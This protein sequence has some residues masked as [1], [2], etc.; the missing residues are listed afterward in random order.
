MLP[1]RDA[2]KSCRSTQFLELPTEVRCIIYIY[3]G[4]MVPRLPNPPSALTRVNRQLREEVHDWIA[5]QKLTL[6][7]HD[8]RLSRLGPRDEPILRRAT[9]IEFDVSRLPSRLSHDVIDLLCRLWRDECRLEQVSFIV[10]D[11]SIS[12]EACDCRGCSEIGH[13]IQKLPSENKKLLCKW[14]LHPVRMLLAKHG[15]QPTQTSVMWKQPLVPPSWSPRHQ[16]IMRDE[17]QD[18]RAITIIPGA[19]AETTMSDLDATWMP[20]VSAVRQRHRTVVD[21]LS[22]STGMDL[23]QRT[24][25]GKTLLMIAADCGDTHIMDRLL[26]GR[27]PGEVEELLSLQDDT[28]A[29]A[30]HLAAYRR[31]LNMVSYLLGKNVDPDTRDRYDRTPLFRAI[32]SSEHTAPVPLVRLL[33]ENNRV[34]KMARDHKG[35]TVLHLSV[36]DP[37]MF[38]YLSQHSGV[39]INDADAEGQTPIFYLAEYSQSSGILDGLINSYGA[40]VNVQ[41]KVGRTALHYATRKQLCENID[42]L[43]KAGADCALEDRWR[44]SPMFYA[45]DGDRYGGVEATQRLV[46]HVKNGNQALILAGQMEKKAIELALLKMP[47]VYTDFKEENVRRLLLEAAR[48]GR[49]DIVLE[50]LY[51]HKTEADVRD[52]DD[53][54]P[55]SHAAETGRRAVIEL[56]MERGSDRNLKDNRGLTPVDYAKSCDEETLAYLLEDWSSRLKERDDDSAARRR[57]GQKAQLAPARRRGLRKAVP[58]GS[59]MI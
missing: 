24:T 9:N 2:A 36:H 20:L 40:L 15:V 30:I 53:R 26:R 29:T 47:T 4:L 12:D 37:D 32:Q 45:V 44:R 38:Q 5:R 35:R 13:F 57:I 1:P 21:V 31:D 41:D 52:D 11:D 39:E 56:L 48:D 18:D 23:K 33:C 54:T 43:L 22:S 14:L 16:G 51:L 49:D 34:N 59:Q 7:I 19:F 28:G 58:S 27:N 55:L 42:V 6:A 10:L 25:G 46:K 50:I 8:R 17:W 3:S